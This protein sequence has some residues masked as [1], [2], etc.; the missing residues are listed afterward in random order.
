[1]IM[2]TD[3]IESIDGNTKRIQLTF[4]VTDVNDNF[5]NNGKITTKPDVCI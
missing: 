2:K 4:L 1:M 3:C 5:H